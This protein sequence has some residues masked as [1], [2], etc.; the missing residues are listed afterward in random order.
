LLAE[1]VLTIS[2]GGGM[3]DQTN[4]LADST[5]KLFDAHMNPCGLILM[6]LS[7][8]RTQM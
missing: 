7:R 2:H 5:L 4:G 8:V 6:L 1:I 3:E